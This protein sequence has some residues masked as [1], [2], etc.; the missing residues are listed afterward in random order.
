MRCDDAEFDPRVDARACRLLDVRSIIAA[1]VLYERDIVGLLEVFS[2]QPC[3]FDEGDVAV[4]KG[5]SPRS[6]SPPCLAKTP[7]DKDGAPVAWGITVTSLSL[8]DTLLHLTKRG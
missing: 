7:R 1:P 4:V 3:A 8:G 6:S 2:T 5:S